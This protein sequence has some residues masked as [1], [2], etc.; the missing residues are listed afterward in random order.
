MIV[1]EASSQ[2]TDV[3]MPLVFDHY[4]NVDRSIWASDGPHTSNSRITPETRRIIEPYRD[5]DNVTVL[6]RLADRFGAPSGIRIITIWIRAR[7][8]DYGPVGKRS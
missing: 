1:Q 6:R 4:A 3:E 2:L 7:L 5:I 8:Y